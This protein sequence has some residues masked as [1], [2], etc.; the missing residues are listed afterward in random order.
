MS[1]SKICKICG[2]SK[3]RDEFR[4]NTRMCRGCQNIH[5]KNYMSNYYEQNKKLFWNTFY[6]CQEK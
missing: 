5:Q 2:E 1:N 6:I 3:D 4:L